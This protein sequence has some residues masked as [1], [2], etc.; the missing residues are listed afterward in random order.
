[1]VYD[2]SDQKVKISCFFKFFDKSIALALQLFKNQGTE[3][4]EGFSIREIFEYHGRTSENLQMQLW[5]QT[6]QLY[7]HDHFLPTRINWF[8]FC[9][10][11][12]K[13]KSKRINVSKFSKT[14]VLNVTTQRNELKNLFYN[15]RIKFWKAS[16]Q[17]TKSKI[18]QLTTHLAW[19]S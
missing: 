19:H 2:F 3:A 10:F 9:F 13:W 8:Q 7:F 6:K 16:D 15:W 11:L 1:M 14:F 12:R 4:R 18:Y 5:T 17:F